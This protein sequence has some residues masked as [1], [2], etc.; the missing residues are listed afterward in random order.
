MHI[1]KNKLSTKYANGKEREIF[2]TDDLWQNSHDVLNEYP[3]ILSTTFSSRN[4]LN[5]NIIYDYLIMDEASQVDIATGALAIF[6]AKNVVIVGDTKQLQNVVTENIKKKAEDIFKRFN[7]NDAYQYTKSFL[8]SVLDAIPNAV[9]TQLREHYRC[10][11]KIIN[12]CNQ[13]F[14]KGELI[15]MTTDSGEEDVLSVVKTVKGNHA[16]NQYNQREISVI[17]EIICE[18]NLITEETG[19][20][21]PYNEQVNGLNSQICDFSAA[22]VHKFQGREK[23][24]IIM[25]MVDNNISDFVDNPYLINVAISRAKKKLILVVNGNG[26]CANRN[27]TDLIDYIQYN[28]FKVV[29]SKIHSIFDYLYKQYTEERI[30]YLKKCKKKFKYDSEKLMYLLINEIISNDKYSNL[31]VICNYQLNML[32]KNYNF[33]SKEE[34]RYAKNPATHLDF[35]IS[36]KISKKPVLVVE[37]DG[38]KYHKKGTKQ[39]TRDLLKNEILEKLEI[40]L[41]RFTTNGDSEKEKLKEH[42]DKLLGYKTMYNIKK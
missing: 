41:L 23:E 20:V 21:A 18:K 19:I 37:V 3:V 35:L 1:L 2:T 27:I 6:G 17:K 33:L 14:Y 11:P 29:D 28:G 8:Q 9:R 40:P 31:A 4:S 38:Y 10:H 24:N 5:P 13:K 7:I 42:L 22:T 34:I 12:F 16:R 36:N 32:I 39:A 26:Q 30:L 15:I 25:S